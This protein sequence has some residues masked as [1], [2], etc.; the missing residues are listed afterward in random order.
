MAIA[1]NEQYECRF[2]C[3]LGE[4]IGINRRHFRVNDIILGTEPNVTVFSVANAIANGFATLYTPLLS[5]N[6]TFRGVSLQRVLTPPRG[7]VIYS[8]PVASTGQVIGDPLPGQCSGLL[9]LRADLPGRRSLLRNYI[10]FPS[11]MS[12]GA[13]GQ[14]VPSY[15]NNLTS[16]GQQFLIPNIYPLDGNSG[17]EIQWVVFPIVPGESPDI[18]AAR[19]RLGWATQRR[20]SYY[21]RSNLTPL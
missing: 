11:E 2:I 19:P 13:T 3:Q 5:A 18:I 10:P 8:D 1:V 14:P 9:Q 15:I 6:A 17:V 7:P 20:R 16:L 21:G 4:Q 12:S